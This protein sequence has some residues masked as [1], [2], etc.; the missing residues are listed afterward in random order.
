MEIHCTLISLEKVL[1][2]VNSKM[3]IAD[4]KPNT[5]LNITILEVLKVNIINNS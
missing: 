4:F 3:I 2:L 1:T 5:L